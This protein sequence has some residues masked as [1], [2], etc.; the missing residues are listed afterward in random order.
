MTQAV[1]APPKRAIDENIELSVLF[2]PPALIKRENKALYHE[3]LAK[4]SRAVNPKEFLEEIWVRDIADLTW[5][6][7]RM[8]RFKAR[9]VSKQLT[10]KDLSDI[11]SVLEAIDAVERIDRMIMNAE[12]RRNVALREIERHRASIAGALRRVTDDVVDAEFEDVGGELRAQEDV[13]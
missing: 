4:V 10:I 1:A 8:R 12:A 6:A 11:G 9:L 3:F 13:A 5:E 7:Q 2:G